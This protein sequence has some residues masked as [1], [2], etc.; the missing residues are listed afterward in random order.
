MSGG[1]ASAVVDALSALPQWALALSEL[2][3]CLPALAFV[4][5][6]V[7]LANLEGPRRWG[8]APLPVASAAILALEAWLC[9]EA[10]LPT[11]PL[12]LLDVA[13]F[14]PVLT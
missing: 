4:V 1:L 7:W 8:V 9:S 3:G 5:R 12:L 10:R 6:I 2:F 14:L 11:A 13:L